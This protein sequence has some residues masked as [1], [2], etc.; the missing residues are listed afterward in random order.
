LLCLTGGARAGLSGFRAPGFPFGL[1]L[2][3]IGAVFFRSCQTVSFPGGT[4]AA[5]NAPRLRTNESR[6]LKLTPLAFALAA[7]QGPSPFHRGSGRV[8]YRHG[9][10]ITTSLATASRHSSSSPRQRQSAGIKW[11]EGFQHS[12]PFPNR[13][14]REDESR[15]AQAARQGEVDEDADALEME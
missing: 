2:H 6:P 9:W 12:I 14:R 3:G 13:S 7:A 15:T 5:K 1:A 8:H 4:Y 10:S 11:P